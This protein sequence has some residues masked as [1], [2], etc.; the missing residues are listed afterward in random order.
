MEI[1]QNLDKRA[2]QPVLL[3]L[4]QAIGNA[5]N[6]FNLDKGELKIKTVEI[7]KGPTYKRWRFVARGR[8]FQVQKKTGHIRMILEGEKEKKRET[9]PDKTQLLKKLS[10]KKSDKKEK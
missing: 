4:K 2:T 10:A 9:S 5:V 7:G 6:N 1:L 8:V 3:T